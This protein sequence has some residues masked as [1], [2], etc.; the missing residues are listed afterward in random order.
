MMLMGIVGLPFSITTAMML[1]VHSY[2]TAHAGCLDACAILFAPSVLIITAIGLLRR[3]HWAHSATIALPLIVFMTQ[4]WQLLQGPLP[5]TTTTSASG[6]LTTTMR[7][8]T[9]ST[10]LPILLVCLGLVWK[11]SSR[12]VREA[13]SIKALITVLAV[14]LTANAQ[15]QIH[16]RPIDDIANRL[17][18]QVPRPI[19]V[20]GPN[21][22]P[23]HHQVFKRLTTWQGALAATA[24]FG[25]T[26]F[27]C[28]SRK[29]YAVALQPRGELGEPRTLVEEFRASMSINQE[30]Y[31]NEVSYDLYLLDKA[32]PDERT[33]IE[34]LLLGEPVTDWPIVEGLSRL[35]TSATIA[36]LQ[37][38]LAT[39]P[40]HEVKMAITDYAADLI[41]EEQRS[42]AIIATVR[43][44]LLTR[45]L[46]L[47][48]RQIV[49]FHPPEI[50]D[51]LLRATVERE[52]SAAMHCAAYL[53]V[54]NGKAKAVFE[55]EHRTFLNRFATRV[56]EDR[57]LVH[58][59]LLRMIGR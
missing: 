25:I 7:S 34:T 26:Y 19:S 12:G 59:E 49:T 52:G 11:L 8:G 46:H 55:D 10:S 39:T 16:Q 20:P 17:S 51:E 15:P 21:A 28:R 47:A 38:A 44:A 42:A 40:Y 13:F 37:H 36:R 41:T 54:L 35:R 9:D 18:E 33:Q 6:V 45:G 1:A 58:A 27:I 56:P 50:I 2:G 31:H 53:L 48:L 29:A 4:G 23:N 14:G 57:L 30:R 43:E 32:T 22:I 5:T 3:R 24:A